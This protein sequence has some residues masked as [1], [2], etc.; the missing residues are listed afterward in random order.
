MFYTI[1]NGFQASYTLTMSIFLS[2]CLSQVYISYRK[3]QKFGHKHDFRNS[4]E[5]KR[6]TRLEFVRLLFSHKLLYIWR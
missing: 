2:L 3:R 1:T 6:V 4:S 5:L